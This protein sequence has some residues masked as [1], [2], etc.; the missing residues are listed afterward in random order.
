MEIQIYPN[1]Q[2]SLTFKEPIMRLLT[3]LVK[4]LNLDISYIN[5]IFVTDS[6]IRKLHKAYLSQDS[7]TDVITFNLNENGAIEGEIYISAQ[8]AEAQAKEYHVPMIQEIF[9]LV[10]HG[11][12]HLA[13][14]TDQDELQRRRMKRKEN[15][16]TNSYIKWLIV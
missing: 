11:C 2:V 6:R 4:K 12:L 16:L 9:R 15:A 7:E 1:K 13:G 14:Y 3:C 5:V 8:R 10:I